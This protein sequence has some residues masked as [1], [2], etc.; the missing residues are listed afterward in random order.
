[1]D[2][3]AWLSRT[4]FS[5]YEQLI[6]GVIVFVLTGGAWWIFRRIVGLFLESQRTAARTASDIWNYMPHA[7]PDVRLTYL[8]WMLARMLLSGMAILM[9]IA[10][11][12]AVPTGHWARVVAVPAVI[13]MALA[14]FG[15]YDR[16]YVTYAFYVQRAA[17][18]FQKKPS[19][20]TAQAPKPKLGA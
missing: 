16:L 12:F 1:M 10:V 19:P 3:H 13:V 15:A 7:P 11:C 2:L 18:D 6:L 20:E 8:A 5:G 17:R 14:M 4:N 9:A